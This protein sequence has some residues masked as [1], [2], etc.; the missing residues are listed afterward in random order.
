[1]SSWFDYDIYGNYQEYLQK[2]NL[3][4][5]ALGV[6]KYPIYEIIGTIKKY[7]DDDIS[8]LDYHIMKLVD[9]LENPEKSSLS[10]ILGLTDGIVSWR[11]ESLEVD[12]YLSVRGQ[13]VKLTKSNACASISWVKK[14]RPKNI[15]RFL[16]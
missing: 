6:I 15:G 3:K 1:M 2:N 7:V 13:K 9:Q 11:L 10:L 14:N 8:S 4:I 16:K 12:D 5:Q